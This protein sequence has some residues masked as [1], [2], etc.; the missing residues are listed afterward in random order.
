MVP[1]KNARK[2]LLVL[3]ARGGAWVLDVGVD[4]A[5][6]WGEGME[7]DR[8]GEG[9]EANMSFTIVISEV[10]KHC[11]ANPHTSRRNPMRSLVVSGSAPNVVTRFNFKEGFLCLFCL[12]EK[13]VNE[14]EEVPMFL[15]STA[16]CFT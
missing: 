10:V 5:A 8:E 15:N 6:G 3:N 16:A 9:A 2:C 14:L 7:V 12:G 1:I 4:G 13:V 11:A